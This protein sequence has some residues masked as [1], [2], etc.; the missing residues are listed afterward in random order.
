M[1]RAIKKI[2]SAMISAVLLCPGFALSQ[3][4][5]AATSQD[6]DKAGKDNDLLL[7]RVW[8]GIQEAQAKYTTGC[9]TLTETRTS[10]LLKVPLVFHGR[11]CASGMDKFFLEYLEPEPVRLVFN[12]DYLNVTTGKGDK[13]TEVI[14]IGDH[15]KKTQA[16][17]SRG[18]SIRNL[19]EQFSITVRESP[20]AYEMR[21]V[22]RSRRFRQKL[23]C[24][25]VVLGRDNFLL[26]TLEIDGTSGVNSVFRIEMEA[27]NL[28]LGENMFRVYRQ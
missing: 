27:V 7:T 19:K 16:Y 13:T 9:G 15:V 25:V 26:R 6:E 8:E 1:T 10:K 12:R 4:E 23:N 21:F 28:V 24:M 11:F 5:A 2:I 22:P 17:F 20:G 18:N 3:K 14:K